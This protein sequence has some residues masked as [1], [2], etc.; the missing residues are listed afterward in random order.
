MAHMGGKRSRD[1]AKSNSDTNDAT[2]ILVRDE[3]ADAEMTQLIHPRSD[4]DGPEGR[5]T[6]IGSA[7]FHKDKQAGVGA[8][9]L[10][11]IPSPAIQI[12]S[13]LPQLLDIT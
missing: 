6:I 10:D 2:R 9:V 7:R 4:I 12:A 1:D 13:Q 8:P 11:W 5:G 3:S